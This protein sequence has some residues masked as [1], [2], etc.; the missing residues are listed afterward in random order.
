MLVK[1]N[2]ERQA[3]SSVMMLLNT[4]LLLTH[5]ADTMEM[6][7]RFPI[8]CEVR[9]LNGWFKMVFV[10]GIQLNSIAARCR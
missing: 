2:M 8:T 9:Q 3:R 4:F 10:H 5:F 7:G 6:H 1:M